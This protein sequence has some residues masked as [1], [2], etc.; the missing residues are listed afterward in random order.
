MS[1][2]FGW[3]FTMLVML[4]LSVPLQALTYEVGGCK[5]GKSY[6]NFTTISAAVIAVPAGSTIEVCP[7]VYSE[8]VTIT[9]PLTLKGIN[10]NNANRSVITINDPAGALLAPNVTSLTTGQP[11]YAQVLVQNVNPAG[12]VNLTG[13]TVDGTGGNAGQCSVGSTLLAGIFY[14]SGTSGTVDEVTAR[15]QVNDGC[16]YGIWVENADATTQTIAIKNS[17]VH[18]V[19]GLGG[20]IA[21]S[22]FSPS[23]L[24]AS[25]SGNFLSNAG[26]IGIQGDTSGEIAGNLLTSSGTGDVGIFAD[27]VELTVSGN[28]VANWYEGIEIKLA[29]TVE[30]NKLSIVGSA[31]TILPNVVAAIK[32]NTAMNADCGFNFSSGSS[33]G[34]VS[35]NVLNDAEN[36][37]ANWLGSPISGNSLYN[38]DTIQPT[39]ASCP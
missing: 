13:I 31:V 23:T 26:F 25:I 32:S 20:A 7:G 11:F 36:A 3:L 4:A 2:Y 17:S 35:S 10:F 5:T 6:V 1:R 33:S 15:N 8:Q 18:D 19:G 34:V 22:S 39:S 9:Q 16:G 27:A 30:S 38:I 28:I 14:A 37:F 12:P 21:A 29:S 24:T